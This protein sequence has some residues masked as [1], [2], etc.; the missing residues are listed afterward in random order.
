VIGLRGVAVAPLVAA[1][2]L[3]TGGCAAG[4]LAA[5]GPVLS[6]VQAV[7]D[8][9]VERT[10]AVDLATTRALTE[11]ALARMAI[12]V[13]SQASAGDGWAL[14]G[15]NKGLSVDVTLTAATERL[16]RIAVRVEAGW[17]TADK[18]TGEEIHNQIARLVADRLERA[19][20]PPPS[21]HGDALAALEAQVRSLR[22]E[23]ERQRHGS[24]PSAAPPALA[25]KPA[26]TVDT[27][28]II[29]VPASYGFAT[30]A[31]LLTSQ[32][33]PAMR[34][35]ADTLGPRLTP[36]P[37]IRPTTLEPADT[38]RAVPALGSA[39]E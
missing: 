21:T 2:A 39:N 13:E 10:I 36:L 28:A 12:P 4:G 18:P 23:L 16:T 22:I 7:T 17:L 31:P 32:G 15:R 3:T 26:V 5:V 19:G 30:T 38:L 35:V 24:T 33:T 11:E 8:R 34:P 1:C 27:T 37:N 14:R 9:S 25:P 6:A 29:S 20:T